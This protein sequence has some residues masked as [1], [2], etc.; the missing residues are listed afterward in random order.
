MSREETVLRVVSVYREVR[1][2]YE[3]SYTR[4]NICSCFISTSIWCDQTKRIVP[5]QLN[6]SS[7]L[8]SNL[9]YIALPSV[10][11][12]VE[13]YRTYQRAPLNYVDFP[14]STVRLDT[15]SALHVTSNAILEAIDEDKNVH[16]GGESRGAGEGEEAAFGPPGV[17]GVPTPTIGAG[18]RREY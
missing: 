3:A 4:E 16:L 15:S 8:H 11:C 13:S 7:L 18:W 17:S 5:E 6:F 2:A 12:L 10:E 14:E 1:D 9:E